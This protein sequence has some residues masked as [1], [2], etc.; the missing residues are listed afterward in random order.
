MRALLASV[1]VTATLLTS[2]AVAQ[3]QQKQETKG[4]E[5]VPKS[6]SAGGRT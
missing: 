5:T 6:G 3:E 4:G 2:Q 1:A